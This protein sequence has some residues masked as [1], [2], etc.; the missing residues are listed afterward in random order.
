MLEQ[1][2]PP[3]LPSTS[4]LRKY[5]TEH[6]VVEQHLGRRILALAA[7]AAFAGA[8]FVAL[9]RPLAVVVLLFALLS[10]PASVRVPTPVAVPAPVPVPVSVLPG[11]SRAQSAVIRALLYGEVADGI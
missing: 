10:I 1:Q 8:A 7:P 6:H 3:C 2:W 5:P 11:E 9:P 4:V